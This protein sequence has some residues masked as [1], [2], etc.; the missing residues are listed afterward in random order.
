MT[1]NK[2]PHRLGFTDKHKKIME[3]AAA[4]LKEEDWTDA[5]RVGMR[6]VV[7]HSEEYVKGK[8]EVVFCTPELESSIKNHPSFF[9]ALCEEG[10]IEWLTPLVLGKPTTP[11]E[12]NP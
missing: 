9:Q 11:P 10:V 12:E 1:G 3:R 6:L 2:Y 5:I 7:N 4:L 8:T